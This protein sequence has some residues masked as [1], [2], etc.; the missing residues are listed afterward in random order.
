MAQVT[1]DEQMDFQEKVIDDADFVAFLDDFFTTRKENTEA[2]KA[3]DANKKKLEE[4]ADKEGWKIGDLVRV[5]PYRIKVGETEA[6]TVPSH[7]R[8][9]RRRLTLQQIGSA[10]A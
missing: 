7:E 2:K 1:S 4:W 10:E 3:H 8:G 6:S 9:A 5:G